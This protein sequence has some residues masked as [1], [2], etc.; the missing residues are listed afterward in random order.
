MGKLCIRERSGTPFACAMSGTQ[1]IYLRSVHVA[2]DS[3]STMPSAV[4][5]VVF[6]H[7]VTRLLRQLQK[8]HILYYTC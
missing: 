4:L 7:Y 5:V 6:H 8:I 3:P 2:E 1:D